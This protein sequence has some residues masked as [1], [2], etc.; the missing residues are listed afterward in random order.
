MSVC[1]CWIEAT[2]QNLVAWNR[3]HLLILMN[4]G[5]NWTGL[6]VSAGLRHVSVVSFVL[7]WTSRPSSLI[8]ECWLALGWSRMT[9]V[10]TAGLFTMW[11]LILHYASLGL[12]SNHGRSPREKARVCRASWGLKLE[13]SH[14]H[15]LHHMHWN[16]SLGKFISRDEELDYPSQWEELQSHVARGG[17]R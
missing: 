5:V 4:L 2:I 12:F 8:C 7:G 6:L 13:L 16:E 11:S 15:L 10:G 1:Y 3:N 9:S 17:S 14:W